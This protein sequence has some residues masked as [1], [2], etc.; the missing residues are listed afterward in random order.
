MTVASSS[1]EVKELIQ[2]HHVYGA[3]A[4]INA[5]VFGSVGEA[6]IDKDV[7]KRMI[8]NAYD[9]LKWEVEA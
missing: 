4:I 3:E 8:D 6:Y 7:L 5:V 1:K 2:N 9:R